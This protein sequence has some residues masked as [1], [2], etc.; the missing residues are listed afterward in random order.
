MKLKDF[1]F[2]G[3]KSIFLRHSHIFCLNAYHIESSSFLLWLKD[4]K[5]P[6]H[7]EFCVGFCNVFPSLN[8]NFLELLSYLWALT[9][10][11]SVSHSL[12]LSVCA[13]RQRTSWST[14]TTHV[15][16]VCPTRRWWRCWRLCLWA[17][18]WM[19]CCVGVIPCFTILMAAPRPACLHPQTPPQGL[20]RPQLTIWTVPPLIT[21]V[22][23]P[24]CKKNL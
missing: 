13:W 10:P 3:S 18:V 8:M 20:P 15:C 11:L 17:T 19:W 22:S 24:G 6:E 2:L 21:M 14:L 5:K 1:F 4:T 16:W 12:S 7:R 23:T 9:F